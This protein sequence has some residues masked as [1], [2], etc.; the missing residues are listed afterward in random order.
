MLLA[1]ALFLVLA[2]VLFLGHLAAK[3]IRWLW[4]L[5]INSGLGLLLLGL[6]NYTARIAGWMDLPINLLTIFI[7]GFLGVPGMILLLIFRL[8][9]MV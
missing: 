1:G 7:A 9:V 2:A 8:L 6:F 4:K 5:A 3:P